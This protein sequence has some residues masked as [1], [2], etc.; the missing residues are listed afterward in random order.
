MTQGLVKV[1]HLRHNTAYNHNDEHVS[2]GVRELVVPSEGHLQ[3]NAKGFDGHD[4]DG[5]GGRADGEV[6]QRVLAAVLR[7]DFVYHYGAESGDEDTVEEK[8]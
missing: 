2:R 6:Y 5:S 1:V 7:G 8:A 3:G 4:G